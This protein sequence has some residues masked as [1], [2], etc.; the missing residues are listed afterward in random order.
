MPGIK[1]TRIDSDKIRQLLARKK[2]TRQAAAE[3]IVISAAAITAALKKGRMTDYMLE[4]IASLLEV[5]PSELCAADDA[6]PKRDGPRRMIAI[7]TDRLRARLREQQ[8]TQA[9]LARR[10]GVA[11]STVQRMLQLGA[12]SNW[13]LGIVCAAAGLTREEL[14]T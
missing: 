14:I 11:L 7:D 8:I 10:C 3:H 2:I 13:M 12:C 5:D 9:E 1:S 4:G 6:Q